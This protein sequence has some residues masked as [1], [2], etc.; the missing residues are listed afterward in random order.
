VQRKLKAAIA[1]CERI[2]ALAVLLG[3]AIFHDWRTK[4][5]RLAELLDFARV[6]ATGDS[7]AQLSLV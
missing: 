1:W 5:G 4:G 6:R 2:N 7:S 3:E